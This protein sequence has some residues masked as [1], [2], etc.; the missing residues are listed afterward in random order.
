MIALDQ[1]IRF[2]RYRKPSNFAT[3][4]MASKR[5]NPDHV[6]VTGVP[7]AGCRKP[8]FAWTGIFSAR[9]ECRGLLLFWRAARGA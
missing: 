5:A 9:C 6:W 3:L 1:A 8:D 4:T 7:V 2:V